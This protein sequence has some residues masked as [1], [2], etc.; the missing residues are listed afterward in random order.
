MKVLS[1]ILIIYLICIMSIFIAAN[2]EDNKKSSQIF[3]TACIIL[4]LDLTSLIVVGI[5][6][7]HL[8]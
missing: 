3:T 7:N 2:M 8:L 6:S 1:M 5:Y 4:I